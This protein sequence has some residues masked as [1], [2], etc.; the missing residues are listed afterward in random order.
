MTHSEL[1]LSAEGHCQPTDTLRKVSR[2]INMPTPLSSLVHFLNLN[3]NQ[4]LKELFLAQRKINKPPQEP[5]GAPR[6]SK[7]KVSRIISQQIL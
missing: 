4:R 2:G 6:R 3:R 1:Q 5:P 7:M